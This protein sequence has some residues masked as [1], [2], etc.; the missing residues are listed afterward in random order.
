MHQRLAPGE[1]PGQATRRQ[2]TA[3]PLGG[4]S[5]APAASQ[6]RGPRPAGGGGYGGGPQ[7]NGGAQ[8]MQR[9]QQRQPMSQP[10]P[11]PQNRAASGSRID[12]GG[13][14]PPYQQANGVEGTAGGGGALPVPLLAAH[15][16]ALH[17][18]IAAAVM[19]QSRATDTPGEGG[20][21][22]AASVAADVPT[23]RR[24][25]VPARQPSPAVPAVAV[26]NAASASSAA[27]IAPERDA[28]LRARLAEVEARNAEMEARVK[29]LEENNFDLEASMQVREAS[30]V[31][32]DD[33]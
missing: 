15:G 1:L 21:A 10:Q 11:H 24:V 13:H 29:E 27:A 26:A 8:Q 7:Q 22:A 17:Q 31:W 33:R 25:G 2:E 9:Q 30:G 28:A 3:P 18:P 4:R 6:E 19:S 23:G 20:A 5:Q 14:G 12:R 32:A 16:S